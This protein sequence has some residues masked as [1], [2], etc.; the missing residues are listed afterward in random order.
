MTNTWIGIGLVLFGAVCGG[1]FALPSKYAGKKPWENLWG[2]FFLFATLLLPAFGL[3]VVKGAWETWSA[4]GPVLLFPI[5]F[6]FLWGLGSSAAGV[7][8]KMVGLSLGFAIIPGVQVIFGPLVPLVFQHPE[9]I[10]TSHGQVILLGI[11]ICLSGV[12]ACGYAGILRNRSLPDEMEMGGKKPAKTSMTIA[13]LVCLVAGILCACL[14]F[15]F[16][17]G[18]QIIE[19]SSTQFGNTPSTAILAVWMP[20]LLGGFFASCGYCTGR[21]FKNKTWKEFTRPGTLRV[22]GLAL[23]MALLHDSAIFFYGLGSQY[24][25]TLGTSVGFAL[26]FTGMMLVGNIH[27]FM[28]GEWTGASGLSKR[29]IKLGIA[30]LVLGICVLGIGNFMA[31]IK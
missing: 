19:I 11:L 28:T 3:L 26:L 12:L 2:P 25:G 29:W 24:L 30:G 1:T 15:A 13:I 18:V 9:H 20:A 23:I 10:A 22:L 6:G 5:V 17:F 27:G 8:Y 21:L 4:A 16:S 14:N 31:E 7:A